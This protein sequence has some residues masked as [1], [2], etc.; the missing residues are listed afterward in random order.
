MKNLLFKFLSKVSPE[1]IDT[2]IRQRWVKPL[3]FK[4]LNFVFVDG[5]N[6]SWYEYPE[7]MGNPIERLSYNLQ[8]YEYLTA[9]M[10]PEMFDNAVDGAN[11][12]LAKGKTI[13]AGAILVR[14]KTIKD[15]VVPTDVLINLIATDLV[16]ED[17]DPSKHNQ[18]IHQEKCNYLKEVIERGDSFFFQLNAVKDLSKRFKI[19]NGDWKPLLNAFQV[20]V[21]EAK[22]ERDILLSMNSDKE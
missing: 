22:R 11:E 16:R 17:E 20:A 4:E 10:S 12:L 13:E 18:T 7:G 8:A 19:S 2:Y 14:A 3:D 1:T 15:E 5:N 9:R 6:L 21:S